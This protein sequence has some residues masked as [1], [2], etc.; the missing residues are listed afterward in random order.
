LEIVSGEALVPCHAISYSI[1]H[2]GVLVE[3]IVGEMYLFELFCHRNA[4]EDHFAA[5]ISQM[6]S[7]DIQDFKLAF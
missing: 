5:F 1:E 7:C 6:I 4:I 3:L 2:F